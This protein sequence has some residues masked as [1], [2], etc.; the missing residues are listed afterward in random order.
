[1][2]NVRLPAIDFDGGLR[3]KVAVDDI[4]SNLSSRNAKSIGPPPLSV[5]QDP[6]HIVICRYQ[7]YYFKM[8]SET[9]IVVFVTLVFLV[10][11][12]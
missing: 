9:L 6:D 4:Y 12:H 7:Y 5:L 10:E 2:T 8:C 3:R 1:M 11:T